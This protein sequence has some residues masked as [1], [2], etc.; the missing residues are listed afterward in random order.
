MD[1]L[2]KKKS[3][4]MDNQLPGL[5]VGLRQLLEGKV[6]QKT[7]DAHIGLMSPAETTSETVQ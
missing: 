4:Y 2:A 5:G 3:E 7:T 1:N 6:D